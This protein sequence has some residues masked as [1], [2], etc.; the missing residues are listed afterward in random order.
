MFLDTGSLLDLFR[1]VIIT[2]I[3][4]QTTEERF[5]TSTLTNAIAAST[6][7]EINEYCSGFVN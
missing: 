5:F 2:L 1:K 7:A 3:E 4:Y 6:T